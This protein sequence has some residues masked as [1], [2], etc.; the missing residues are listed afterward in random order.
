MAELE[1]VTD[2]AAGLPDGLPGDRLAARDFVDRLTL[3]RDDDLLVLDKPAGLAVQKGTRTSLDL[4]AILL[5]AF[6]GAPDRPR[7]THRLDRDTSGCLLVALSLVATRA[8]GRHFMA[9]RIDKEYRALTLG[10]PDAET[11]IIDRPLLK[12]RE[13]GGDRMRPPQNAAEAACAK[14]ASTL[15]EV[16]AASPGARF[17]HLSLKPL[18]GRQ[19]QIRAHLAGLGAPVLGDRLYGGLADLPD[20]IGTRLHLHARRL[21]FLHPATRRTLDVVAPFPPHMTAAS[22]RLGLQ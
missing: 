1:P 15:F 9:G 8:I 14:P 20:G 12:A 19:H 2:T 4:D 21:S 7:L 11:G 22:T 10:L 16:L 3:Y 5:A 13:P 17:A 6:A 18:T